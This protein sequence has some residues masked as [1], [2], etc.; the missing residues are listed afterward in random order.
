VSV[1]ISQN[2]SSGGTRRGGSQLY[3][4]SSRYVEGEELDKAL[5]G[6]MG[7]GKRGVFGYRIQT[8]EDPTFGTMLQEYRTDGQ[9]LAVDVSKPNTNPG[10]PRGVGFSA[11]WMMFKPANQDDSKFR[12]LGRQKVGRHDTLV[13]AFA[14]I[15]GEVPVPAEI[16]MGGGTCSY[17]QQGLVWIDEEAAQIVRLETDLLKPLTDFHLTKLYSSV[18]F[19][20]VRIPEKN[21]TLWMPNEVQIRWQSKEQAGAERHKYSDYR[22]FG[23]TSRIVLP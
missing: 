19:G 2:P 10:S 18:T 14:Q 23:A 1:A 13:V 21:L 4:S 6:L 22:L 20:E 9:N 7:Q 17:L 12:Y 15:P 11:T 5:E 3:D 16:T 8:T